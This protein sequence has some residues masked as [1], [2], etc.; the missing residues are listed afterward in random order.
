M[1]GETRGVGPAGR[2][3]QKEEVSSEGF[4]CEIQGLLRTGESLPLPRRGLHQICKSLSGPY[5]ATLFVEGSTMQS[6][7]S[8]RMLRECG[9]TETSPSPGQ[10]HVDVD[11]PRLPESVCSP[12]LAAALAGLRGNAIS[13]AQ[14]RGFN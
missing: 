9:Y 3:R 5:L 6:P 4:A 14:Y 7:Q 11:Q 12:C 1:A 10:P 13:R 8:E 2:L